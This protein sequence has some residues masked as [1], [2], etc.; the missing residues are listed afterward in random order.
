MGKRLVIPFFAKT[1]TVFSD[2]SGKFEKFPF[3]AS[4]SDPET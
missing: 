3:V 1:Y 2:I 4:I